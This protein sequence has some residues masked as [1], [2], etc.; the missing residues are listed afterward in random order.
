MLL[1]AAL[2]WGMAFSAQSIGADY[3]EGW[4]FLTA[5]SFLA[6][7]AMLPFVLAHEK[8]RTDTAGTIS[9]AAVA[10][11]ER[12]SSAGA[13]EVSLTGRREP[14]SDRRCGSFADI[15]RRDWKH[16]H[17]DSWDARTGRFACISRRDGKAGLICGFFLCIA[18]GLQQVGIAYTTAAKSGFIT[19]LYVVL[20]PLLTMIVL[21]RRLQGKLW[22]SIVLC[23]LGLYLLCMTDGLQSVSYGDLLTLGSAFCFACQIMCV[24]Y[25]IQSVD[26]LRLTF[27]QFAAETVIAAVFMLLLEHPTVAGLRQAAIPIA[28]AGIL[29]SAVGYS[30]QA[31]GQRGLNPTVAS[32]AMCMESVFSAVGGWLILGERLT[33]RESLGC[34]LMF[35][36]IVLAEVPIGRH[37]AA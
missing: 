2:V 27:L 31:F 13:K 23:V 10:E 20:V 24:D 30:L 25:Y 18:S 37:R 14:E 12:Q 16:T 9:D 28:Y 4:T 32:L 6:V 29:S 35:A 17:P 33:P 1:L 22:F 5:R 36:A 21:H 11:E 8:K 3:V 34:A 26:P 15:S 19:A 7:L